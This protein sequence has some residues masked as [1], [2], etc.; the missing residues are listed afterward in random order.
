MKKFIVALALAVSVTP[1]LADR[2]Y[3]HPYHGHYRPGWGW[4]APAVIGG[5]VV[6]AATRPPVIVQQPPVVIQQPVPPV[7]VQQGL[8]PA[9][10]GF[11]YENILDASCNC[12]KTVLVNN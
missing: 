10:L 3:H 1:A 9:P 4:I 8:P 2:Y 11:H 6:Y 12:Y 5:A 7:Y